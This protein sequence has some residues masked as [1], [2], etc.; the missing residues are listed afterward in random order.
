MDVKEK[1][2]NGCQQQCLV[3][4]VNTWSSLAACVVRTLAFQPKSDTLTTKPSTQFAVGVI[5]ISTIYSQYLSVLDDQICK[6][7]VFDGAE[8]EFDIGFVGICQ[9]VASSGMCSSKLSGG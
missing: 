5:E 6:S 4:D 1:C 3:M 7:Y 2:H 8:F 9:L